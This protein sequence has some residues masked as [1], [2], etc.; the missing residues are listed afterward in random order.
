MG[1]AVVTVE[2]ASSS[3]NFPFGGIS[4]CER[5]GNVAKKSGENQPR[6]RN[7]KCNRK[8]QLVNFPQ[9]LLLF[10]ALKS[11]LLARLHGRRATT[12]S[13]MQNHNIPQTDLKNTL[14]RESGRKIALYPIPY[15]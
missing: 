14:A 11:F 12:D 4:F 2:T 10:A 1:G 9:P 15:A 7:K 13:Y 6:P 3:D 5:G 8:F